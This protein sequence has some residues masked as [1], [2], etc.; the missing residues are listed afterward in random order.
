M[1]GQ[2]LSVDLKKTLTPLDSKRPKLFCWTLLRSCALKPQYHH[3]H[4]HIS[5]QDG[6]GVCPPPQVCSV[7]SFQPVS[8]Y[9]DTQF[10]I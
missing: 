10:W 7:T 6:V 8:M 1:E 2:Q 3:H 9:N 5:E 4:H